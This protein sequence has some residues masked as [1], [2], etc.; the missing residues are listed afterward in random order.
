MAVGW[1]GSARTILALRAYLMKGSATQGFP[2]RTWAFHRS[3]IGNNVCWRSVTEQTLIAPRRA[4][5]S[6]LSYVR[7]ANAILSSG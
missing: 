2:P 3:I 5:S 6:I 4:M 7:P 1:T